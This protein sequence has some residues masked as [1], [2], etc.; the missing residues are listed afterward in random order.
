MIFV[1][2][3]ESHKFNTMFGRNK[4]KK[5]TTLISKRDSKITKHKKPSTKGKPDIQILIVST[6]LTLFGVIMVFSAS[7]FL[8]LQNE[9][10]NNDPFYIFNR[11]LIWI[12]ASV[13]FAY[14]F[15]KLPINSL[16]KLSLVWIIIMI[17]IMIY[18]L[19][20][21]LSSIA[22][23][24]TCRKA[25]E[26]PLVNTKNCGTR[27]IDLGFFD[28]QP[29]EFI[30]IPLII[31]TAYWISL[32][33]KSKKKVDE[34][35]KSFKN[36][37]V[38]HFLLYVS[39]VFL[40]FILL[41]IVVLLVLAQRDL[42]SAIV[43]AVPIIAIYFAAT[44]KRSQIYSLIG[45]LVIGV[46]AGLLLVTQQDYR[47]GRSDSYVEILL[48]GEPSVQSQSSTGFQVWHGLIA[49]G[50]GGVF[51]KGYNESREKFYYLQEAAYTDSI[52]AVTAEEFGL[53]GSVT[54]L[55]SFLFLGSRGF[56]NASENPSKFESYVIIGIT[57]WI[58]IQAF[59]NIAANL[60]II[61][62]AGMPLPFF[63]YGGSNT[64]MI[65]IA[66]GVLLNL[67]RK[68]ISTRDNPLFRRRI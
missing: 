58:L 44:T 63:S 2:Q 22:D 9:S 6:F 68:H 17:V 38:L 40:P 50:S 36:N 1:I 35:I 49:I 5:H 66:I 57:T 37:E 12:F 21:A 65:L 10:F 29:S 14:I 61:P 3:Y 60:S 59:L 53:I 25:I 30:K 46:F 48:E 51:G 16:T 34:Y 7:A 11:H 27:W 42:D 18:M 55:L 43:I 39:L 62:F 41:A 32:G 26:M 47:R 20:E 28:M 54:I 15:Y 33:D 24:Q 4:S 64:L 56:R 8:S 52:F 19:P 45:V 13:I 31:F 23:P 67:S